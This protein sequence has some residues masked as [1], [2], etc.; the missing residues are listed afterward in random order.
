MIP[1]TTALNVAIRGAS[2]AGDWKGIF[3]E[4]RNAIW[5]FVDAALCQKVARQ[6][7]WEVFKPPPS[8][9]LSFE[10]KVFVTGK[11]M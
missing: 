7:F 3:L 2:T 6:L 5:I 1:R 8:L 9:Q 10:T 11:K 4:T